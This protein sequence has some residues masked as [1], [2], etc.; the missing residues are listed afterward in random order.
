MSSDVLLVIWGVFVRHYGDIRLGGTHNDVWN[1]EPRA[2][3]VAVCGVHG[4]G[5]EAAAFLGH[6]YRGGCPGYSV[7]MRRHLGCCRGVD[8]RSAYLEMER[9]CGDAVVGSMVLPVWVGVGLR[10]EPYN[11]RNI[12]K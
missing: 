5:W 7:L 10:L 1:H 3:F 2:M 4:L 8:Y 6:G 9:R 11:K 12:Y